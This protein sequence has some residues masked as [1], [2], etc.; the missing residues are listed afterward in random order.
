ML[1]VFE[2]RLTVAG[3]SVENIISLRKAGFR[4]P[5]LLGN[6]VAVRVPKDGSERCRP[7][8]R[9]VPVGTRQPPKGVSLFSQLADRSVELRDNLEFH[10]IGDPTSAGAN[11]YYSANVTWDK[12]LEPEALQQ[13]VRDSAC[14]VTTA[15]SERVSLSV[16][17]AAMQDVPVVMPAWLGNAMLLSDD[18][19][20]VS[21]NFLTA[22]AVLDAVVSVLNGPGKNLSVKEIWR[23]EFAQKNVRHR[24][25][26][27]RIE[28]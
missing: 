8:Q 16:V 10:W 24:F 14:F 25:E 28:R 4:R 26:N 17:E 27:P 13:F 18:G 3:V 15:R 1:K 5:N 2:N 11:C 21:V 19:A 6:I 22:S 23:R 20:A 7:R 12:P 9:V